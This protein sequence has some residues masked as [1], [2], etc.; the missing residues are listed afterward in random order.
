M[1]L[2]N[3]AAFLMLSLITLAP[4]A[5]LCRAQTTPFLSDSE[6]SML[7]NEISGDRS[8]EHI[9]WLSHWHRDSGMEGYFKAAEYVMK[10]AKEAGLEDVRFVEQPLP[11]PN[12]TAR[13]G[14]L[15]MVEP[16][17]VKLAD[18]GDHAVHLADGSHSANVTAELV[19]IGEASAEELQKLDV[20]GKIVLTTANPQLAVQRAVWERGALGVITFSPSESK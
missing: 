17:E 12:Y 2:R 11:G 19:W 5:P 9:R 4:L 18:I 13:V 6:I 3:L 8:F 15:W 10:A 20:A 7:A 16:L 14:E 1:Y